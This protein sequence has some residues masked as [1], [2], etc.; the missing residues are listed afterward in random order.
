MWHFTCAHIQKRR[1]SHAKTTDAEPYIY[2]SFLLK[3]QPFNN[4]KIDKGHRAQDIFRF[5]VFSL[6]KDKFKTLCDFLFQPTLLTQFADQSLDV[7]QVEAF[8]L[9]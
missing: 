8:N 6:I 7:N 9:K 1:H 3:M 5:A 2:Q 4:F